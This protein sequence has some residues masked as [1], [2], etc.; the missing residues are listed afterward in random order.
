[1]GGTTEVYRAHSGVLFDT[2][3]RA[4]DSAYTGECTLSVHA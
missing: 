1:M 2:G 4:L 3:T